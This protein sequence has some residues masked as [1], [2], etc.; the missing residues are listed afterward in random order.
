MTEKQKI[1]QQDFVDNVINDMIV[2]LNPTE[3][4]LQWNITVISEIRSILT[5]YF[6]EDLRLCTD[7]EFYLYADKAQYYS[8]PEMFNQLTKDM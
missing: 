2:A 5:R 4:K 8:I 6:V 1:K 3:N 7:E